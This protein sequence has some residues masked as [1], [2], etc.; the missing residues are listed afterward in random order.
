MHLM[1]VDLP[2]PLAPSR[3]CTSP[4]CTSK[5]TPSRAVPPGY[6]LVRPRTSR[7]GPPARAISAHHQRAQGAVRDLETGL[8]FVF[9]AAPHGIFVLH[10]ERAIEAALVENVDQAHPVDLAQ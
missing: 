9:G 10:G 4:A 5:S 1:S 2:A 6:R 7:K 8:H 3:Q